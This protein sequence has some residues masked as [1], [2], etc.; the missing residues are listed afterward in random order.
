[1]FSCLPIFSAIFLKPK[2]NWVWN[3]ILQILCINLYAHMLFISALTAVGHIIYH[4]VHIKT[5]ANEIV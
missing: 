5:P 3:H 1:M 2:Q 4:I